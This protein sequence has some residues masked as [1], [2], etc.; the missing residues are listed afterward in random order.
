MKTG[1]WVF[2]LLSHKIDATR[3][4]LVVHIPK[5]TNF[6]WQFF[7]ECD[8]YLYNREKWQTLDGS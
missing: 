4:E 2:E 5:T 7:W 6:C 8:G 3:E 1:I